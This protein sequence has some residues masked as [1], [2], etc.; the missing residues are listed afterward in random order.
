MKYALILIS[1]LTVSFAVQ[2]Q[3]YQSNQA[4]SSMKISG[5]S[6][7]HDWHID[8]ETFTAK[9]NMTGET[10][11][12]ASFT[13]VVKSLKSGTSSMDDNTYEALKAKEYPNISF[14]STSI[15]GTEGKL[16]VKGN[17]TIAGSTKPVT[18][19][20]TLEKW[21]ENSVTVKGSYTFKMS[22]FGIDP[23]RAMLGTIRTGDE[24]TIDFKLILYKK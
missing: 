10:L 6:T 2:A 1:L 21:T 22:E 17:L 9:A 23:P 18:I 4:E 3:E 5:T 7:L 15:T 11:E 12:N 8:V 19:A 24:I 14:K 16:S 20:T 13:A